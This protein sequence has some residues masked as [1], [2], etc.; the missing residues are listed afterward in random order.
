M[1]TLLV[2]NKKNASTGVVV[3]VLG[4]LTALAPMS[5]DMYLPAFAD[6]ARSLH[7]EISEVTLSLSLF[8]FGLS[9][10]QLIYGP[11]LE[12]FGR[13][14]PLYVGLLIY[15]LSAAAC[16]FSASVE[17]LIVARLFQALG[18]CVGMVATRAIVR[19]LFPIE[20]NA[21]VFSMMMLVTSISPIIAPSA[22]GFIVATF[23]WRYIFGVV[24]LLALIV[25]AGIYFLLPESHEPDQQIS[26]KPKFILKNYAAVLKNRQFLLYSLAGSFCSIALFGYIASAPAVFIS[27]FH[28]EQKQFGWIIG[29]ISIGI[30]LSSQINNLVLKRFKMHQ[31][32]L[33]ATA[34]QAGIGVVFIIVSLSGLNHIS[35]V[36]GFIFSMLTCLGFIISNTTSLAMAPMNN[37]AG[38]ASALMGSMQMIIG[39]ASSAF[40]S[41]L[42]NKSVLTMAAVMTSGAGMVLLLLLSS[43]RL[44]S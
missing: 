15:I 9:T 10:G 42:A 44:Y 5:I 39:A 24:I 7:T 6:I 27:S 25:L 16:A 31:V 12:R 22:G 18:G 33:T 36:I 3:V 32:A 35:V 1:K 2:V 17:Q 41:A 8:F 40:I 34:V 20:Q 14:R 19:D 23:G 13:K 11:L 37:D 38:D 29:S 21:K 4:L 26:L 43:R 30:V 28:M